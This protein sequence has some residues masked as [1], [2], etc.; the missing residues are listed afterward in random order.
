MRK[1]G[2]LKNPR[3]P[4]KQ[5]VVKTVEPVKQSS[6]MKI[7]A[8]V[9]VYRQPQ[10][11][12]N[13]IL[14]SAQ[15]VLADMFCSRFIKVVKKKDSDELTIRW[16]D[17]FV[18]GSGKIDYFSAIT[19]EARTL[20]QTVIL[21][22]YHRRV[23]ELNSLDTRNELDR[24]LEGKMFRLYDTTNKVIYKKYAGR[25]GTVSIINHEGE[26]VHS[27][28]FCT[29]ELND[30]KG[31]ITSNYLNITAV[32]KQEYGPFYKDGYMKVTT[33]NNEYMFL[34]VEGKR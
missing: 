22:E 9:T 28:F 16:A 21:D 20:A 18:P 29:G 11:K 3:G 26:N 23:A 7:E 25:T 32:P 4:V 15:L 8:K 13:E 12:Y 6:P 34:V 1:G 2:P 17:T 33:M 27:V 30:H 31:F 19:K 5:E 14:A 10:G 24:Y